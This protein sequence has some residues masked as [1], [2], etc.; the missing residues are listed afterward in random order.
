MNHT[1]IILVDQLVINANGLG[2]HIPCITII[3]I[4]T[5]KS[6]IQFAN[7]LQHG[8]PTQSIIDK[9]PAYLSVKFLLKMIKEL[10]GPAL[11]ILDLKSDLKFATFVISRTEESNQS[12]LKQG[13]GKHLRMTLGLIASLLFF[14]LFFLWCFCFFGDVVHWTSLASNQKFAR[15]MGSCCIRNA[16]H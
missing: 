1:R 10:L 15:A 11:P 2:P 8:V 13:R 4:L 16:W 3:L 9:P 7:S 6:S 14:G 12:W 5:G